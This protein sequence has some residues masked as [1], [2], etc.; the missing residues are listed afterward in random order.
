[1]KLKTTELKGSI[2]K[3]I[4]FRETTNVVGMSCFKG[5][6]DTFD[7]APLHKGRTFIICS[8][9]LVVLWTNSGK[10]DMREGQPVSN[11]VTK[12]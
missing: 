11:H 9:D 5:E 10:N 8:K 6:R 7:L 2:I 1:M 4:K 12:S 3:T